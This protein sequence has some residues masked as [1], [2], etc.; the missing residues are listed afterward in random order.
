[1]LF[2]QNAELKS[3]LEKSAQSKVPSDP[4]IWLQMRENFEKMILADH[5]FCEK[6]EI[7]YILWQLH[8]KRIEEFRHHISSASSAASQ[9]GKSSV[10]A[11]RIKRIKSA[12]RSFLSEASGFY[13]DLMYKIKSSYGLPVG[14]FSE[15]PENAGNA[16]KNDKKTSDVKKALISCHRCLIYLGDLA[17]Y[18]G[19]FGDGD[20]ATREYAAASSYYKEAASICP[21]S[22]NPHHQ[23]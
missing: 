23:V 21:S 19:M 10:N 11:D 4:N 8:Y 18:K 14:Y 3:L 7:E 22:G 1:M 12:F 5:D 17:R 6:H 16:A 13:H 20:S 15:S 2:A 9:N